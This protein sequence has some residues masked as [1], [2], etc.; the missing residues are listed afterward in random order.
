MI[1][2]ELATHRFHIFFPGK[3]VFRTLYLAA[4]PEIRVKHCRKYVKN[5]L[6]L[7][8]HLQSVLAL[9]DAT[10]SF[11]SSKAVNSFVEGFS[12]SLF[13]I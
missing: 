9:P 6:S 4:F 10:C 3:Y 5:T 13:S 8:Y 7:H 1:R 11:E 2:P 12:V